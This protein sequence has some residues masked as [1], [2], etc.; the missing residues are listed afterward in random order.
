MALLSAHQP[1]VIRNF[2]AS[3]EGGGEWIFSGQVTDPNESVVG[4]T[5]RF[6][7]LT[8]L[9]GKT[10]TVEDDGWFHLVVFLKANENGCATAQTISA[11]GL[12]SNL[13]EYLVHQT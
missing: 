3:E 7:G 8:S 10:A 13:A 4:L 6:G 12:N 11:A 9:K 5:V 1:P 2:T